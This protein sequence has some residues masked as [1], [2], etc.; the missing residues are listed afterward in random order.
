M[1][2]VLL[3]A[4]F[5][6]FGLG[7]SNTNTQEIK[8]GAMAAL[9][10]G[11]M[12]DWLSVGFGL[13]VAVLWEVADGLHVGGAT[14]YHHFLGEEWEIIGTKF[15]AVDFQYI[16]I[17][18]TARYFLA[19]NFYLGADLGYGIA[20]GDASGGDLYYRPKAG[21]NFGQIGLNVSYGGLDNFSFLGLGIEF[22]L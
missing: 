17:A 6:I 21:Y 18:A 15:P 19:D 14:G 16:P 1:K 10:M 2:R 20:V 12:D 3:I 9:P 13:D 7:V 11:E 4:L 22:G 5:A 8:L